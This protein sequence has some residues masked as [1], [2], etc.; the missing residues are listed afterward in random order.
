MASPLQLARTEHENEAPTLPQEVLH[1]ILSY[2]EAATAL[3]SC[4]GVCRSWRALFNK[5]SYMPWA[6][7]VLG[8]SLRR[9]ACA[10]DWTLDPCLV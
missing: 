7:L 8:A 4:R 1:I 9:V 5:E 2:V 6:K 10:R 3:A